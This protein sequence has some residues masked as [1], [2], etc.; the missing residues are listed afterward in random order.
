MIYLASPYSHPDP[1]IMKTR[2]LL[3]EQVTAHLIQQGLFVYSPIVH[4]HA[5]SERYALPTTFD[6]W[7]AYNFDILRHARELVV[8]H[9]EGWKESKGVQGEIAFAQQFTL[10]IMYVNKEGR[11]VGPDN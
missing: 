5:M 1:L 9:I 8:L 6:F 7:K 2:F 10:P 4:C 11:I 3:A